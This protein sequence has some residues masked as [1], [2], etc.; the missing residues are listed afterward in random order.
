MFIRVNVS[1]L[2]VCCF[3]SIDP[4]Y[5]RPD[6]QIDLH[7]KRRLSFELIIV[8]FAFVSAIIYPLKLI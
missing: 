1:V 7:V 5:C 3:T 2:F 6:M 8:D 4:F